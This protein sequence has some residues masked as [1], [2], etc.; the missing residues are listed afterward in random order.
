MTIS[1]MASMNFAYRN[2]YINQLNATKTMGKLS[3]GY[4]INSAG[5]DAAG[6]A[7]SQGM[8][9]QIAGLGKAAENVTGAVSLVQTADGGLSNS[10]DVLNRM[11]ELAVQASNGAYSDSDRS[12]I[13]K[14]MQALKSQLDQVASSTNYNGTKLLDGSLAGNNGLTFQIGA[15]GGA[16]QQM[17]LSVNDMSSAG[18]GLSNIGVGTL[19]GANS[20]IDAIDSAINTLSTERSNLGATQNRLVSSFNSINLS[21]QNLYASESAIRDTDMVKSI[22]EFTQQSIMLKASQAMMAQGMNMSRSNLMSL[23]LR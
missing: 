16:D 20:A 14:E 10:A 13:N 21:T 12:L 5:D 9:G 4:R 23:I 1:N 22:L 8:R 17:S 18:L 2:L 7:I 3:S 15:N 19:S 6:L 11:R